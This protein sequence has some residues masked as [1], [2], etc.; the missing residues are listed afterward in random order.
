MDQEIYSGNGAEVEVEVP[1]S[2]DIAINVKSEKFR[3]EWKQPRS[4][5]NEK[6]TL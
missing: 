6:S 1:L 4:L 2:G 3:Q 5:Y